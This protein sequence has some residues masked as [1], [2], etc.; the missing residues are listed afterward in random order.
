MFFQFLCYELLMTGYVVFPIPRRFYHLHFT[1][2][3]AALATLE[4][5]W[6]QG[7]SKTHGSSCPRLSAATSNP[8]GENRHDGRVAPRHIA[9]LARVLMPPRVTYK[10]TSAS[11]KN[12]SWN[13]RNNQF[14]KGWLRYDSMPVSD[15]IPVTDTMPN[16]NKTVEATAGLGT[17]PPR[18]PSRGERP[19]A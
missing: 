3:A 4:S 16:K 5:I 10:G 18:E 1:N 11:M 8:Q 15:T 17:R 13:M 6:V 19:G 14:R 7:C 9:V 2:T 12:A